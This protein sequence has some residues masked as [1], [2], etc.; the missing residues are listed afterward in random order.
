MPSGTMWPL[1]ASNLDTTRSATSTALVPFFLATATVT[2]G[3]RSP[4]ARPLCPAAG[5]VPIH[6]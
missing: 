4:G 5:P 3:I 6:T 2:A 1:M